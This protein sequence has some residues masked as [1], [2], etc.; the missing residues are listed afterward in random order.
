VQPILDRQWPDAYWRHGSFVLLAIDTEADM[1][2]AY[3][4]GGGFASE[5]T[6]IVGATVLR[7]RR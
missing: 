3:D 1:S 7:G 6:E 5:T 2:L 4:P